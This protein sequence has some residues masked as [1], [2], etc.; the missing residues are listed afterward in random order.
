MQL[1]DRCSYINDRWQGGLGD[2]LVE[3][4]CIFFFFHFMLFCC[5]AH[6]IL[7]VVLQES[8]HGGYI[9]FYHHL[10]PHAQVLCLCWSLAH[11]KL[12]FQRYNAFCAH[13]MTLYRNPRSWHCHSCVGVHYK[14]YMQSFPIPRASSTIRFAISGPKQESYSPW[15]RDLW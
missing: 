6:P 8:G 15:H 13:G 5:W 1:K 14:I 4:N 2:W 11:H 10:M 9:L 12:L 7:W 3:L